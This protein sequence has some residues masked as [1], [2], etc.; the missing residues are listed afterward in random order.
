MGHSAAIATSWAEAERHLSR[1][2]PALLILDPRLPDADG[3]E[4]LPQLAGQQPVI[5]LTAY[6][7]VRNAVRAVKAG[8][9]EY[10]IKPVNL[11]Q[12]E[13]EVERVLEADVLRRDYQFYQSQIK[14]LRHGVLVGRSDALREVNQLIDAV[15]RSDMTVLVQG[16]S[17]VGKELVANEIHERSARAERHFTTVDCCT[18]HENLFES[19]L[20]GHERGAFTGAD[21]QKKG[22]IEVAEG[23]TLFLDEIGE[24]GPASQAK[25]LRVIESGQFRRLGGTKDL[26]ADVRIVAATNRDL[27]QMTETGTSRSDLYYR[28]SAFIIDVPPLRERREDI[29]DLVRHFIRLFSRRGGVTVSPAATS[30]LVTYHW[31]G[32]VRELRNVIERAMIVSGD[33]SQLRLEH[34]PPAPCQPNK[35]TRFTLDFAHEPTIDEIEKSYLEIL[36]MKYA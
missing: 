7:S 17:G 30:Q 36:L 13:L 23:G 28:I 24:I 31:P 32:N 34:L 4:L 35:P 18:L 33:E 12:L 15:A 1:H 29:P 10:L 14:S 8:A 6:G 19:E 21:R 22:L 2:E 20:F 11:E 5:V 25:L 27:E 26:H 9:A 3:Y 16:E